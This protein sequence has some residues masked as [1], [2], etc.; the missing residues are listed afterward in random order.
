MALVSAEPQTAEPPTAEHQTAGRRESRHIGRLRFWPAVGAITGAGFALRLYLLVVVHWGS[1]LGFNDAEYYSQQGIDLAA[2]RLFRGPGGGP[3]AEHGPLTS[4]LVAPFSWGPDPADTQRL[5]TLLVGT[6]TIV[7][8]ALVARHLAGERAGIVAAGI[9]AVYPNLWM[10]DGLVMSEAPAATLVALWLLV[11]ARWAE[12]P[13]PRRAALWGVVGGLATL[14]RSELALL[15]VAS[16]VIVLM[17]SN[18]RDFRNALVVVALAG[19]VVGPWVGWN[20]VRFERPVTLTTNDGTTIRGANCDET[21]HGR[22][23]G[24]WSVRCLVLDDGAVADL[25]S[26]ER[27]RAWREEGLAYARDHASR[28]PLV[29]AARAGR[30]LGV[31]GLGYQVDEDVRDQR[32]RWAS[33][34]GIVAWWALLPLAA[35]A[36]VRARNEVRRLLL[37]PTVAVLVTTLA[38]YGGHRIRAPMEP[39]LVVAA[40]LAIAG[41]RRWRR[42]RRRPRGG[43]RT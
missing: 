11:G 40:A 24:S 21:Y 29:V 35:L 42:D 15:V 9:A 10:N 30:L 7:I 36:M 39:A 6:V 32:P 2:G 23:M 22:A 1:P 13:G 12:R 3:G 41:G 14:T 20:L 17:T 18:R 34:S 27:S 5:A 38:F 31:Y 43:D 19:T 28:V 16:V 26:S 4:V 37:S 25:E 33:W 8:L